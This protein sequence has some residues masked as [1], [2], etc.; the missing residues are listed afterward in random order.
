[1]YGNKVQTQMESRALSSD[2]HLR[3]RQPRVL[4]SKVRLRAAPQGSTRM[5]DVGMCGF[6]R[7]SDNKLVDVSRELMM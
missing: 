5:L 3:A 1:M 6:N 7:H 4:L 2:K